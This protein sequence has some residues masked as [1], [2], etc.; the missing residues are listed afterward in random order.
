MKSNMENDDD[1]IDPDE[2]LYQKYEHIIRNTTIEDLVKDKNTRSKIQKQYV[3]YCLDEIEP[4]IEKEIELWVKEYNMHDI[5]N[6]NELC[7]I[8]MEHIDYNKAFT[9][10]FIQNNPECLQEYVEKKMEEENLPKQQKSTEEHSYIAPNLNK[11][12]IW[13]TRKY[14]E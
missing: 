13:E 8:M 6:V 4:C 11:K 14:V 1:C 2:L 12:F 10:E 7:S 9:K 3:D 5:V